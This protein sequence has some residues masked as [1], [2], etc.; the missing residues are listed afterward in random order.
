MD[1]VYIVMLHT[2]HCDETSYTEAVCA[3]LDYQKATEYCKKLN[4]DINRIKIALDLLH[5]NQVKWIK[6]NPRPRLSNKATDKE[7]MFWINYTQSMQDEEKRFFSSL[8]LLT[9]EERDN[10][11]THGKFHYQTDE[12]YSVEEL[13]IKD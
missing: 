10:L 4:A 8:D 9:D 12:S 13:E 7:R 2:G 5:K 11:C 1:K 6:E 3:F